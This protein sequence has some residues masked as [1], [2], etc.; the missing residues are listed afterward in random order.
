MKAQ[1]KFEKW[2]S[3]PETFFTEVLG[4]TTLEYYQKDLLYKVAKREYISVRACH[5]VGKT[6]TVARIVLWFLC[7]FRNSIVISTAPTFLQVDTL[8]WGE[9]RDAYKNSKY[10]IGGTLLNTKLKKSDKW[11]AVGFSPQNKAGDSDEQIGST[12]QGFHSDHV[13][14]VFDEATGISA[15]VKKMAEGLM[16]SGIMVRF[17]E[18]GN[19][20]TRACG[21]F[22]T[23]SSPKY[24]KV[25]W[26]C[27]NSPNVRANGFT[28][29]ADIED[30]ID[31]LLLMSEDDRLKAI[32]EYKKPVPHLLSAQWVISYILDWGMDHPL[33]VSKVF[34][35]FPENDDD[36]LMTMKSVEDC[37]ERELPYVDTDLRCIGIDVARYGDD[38]SVLIEMVAK[39]QTSCK[40]AVK[41]NITIVTGLS[42]QMINND[43]KLYRTIVLVD[44][45]GI[46][47]GVFDNL[48]EAQSQGVIHK[49]VE[50]IE[51]H[52]GSG[53][54]LKSEEKNKSQ[55]NIKINA[56][57][58]ARFFNLKSRMFQMLANDVNSGLDLFDD[59]NFLKELPTIKSEPN[60]KG[61][62]AVESKDKYRTRTKQKSPDYADA[63]ALCNFGRYVKIRFGSFK[64]NTSGE[65][66]PLIKRKKDYTRK[67][68]INPTSY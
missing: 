13:L 48:V 45:T 30:E 41:K 5:S 47:S 4:V 53:A 55:E 56:Q 50:L 38:K 52:F 25:H 63:L 46:G 16:T 35:D 66:K 61:Q 58:K 3:K 37:I 59:S 28:C 9:I 31:R 6:W 24:A 8:L 64:N 19:P 21:F 67:T 10:A 54:V 39:T 15:D 14:V 65:N 42:I 17:V 32:E 26:S 60:S 57:T 43:K 62:M 12:F 27:F 1:A 36:V 49:D 40:Q 22:K 20:T 29:K 68:K 44:A 51:V 2:R 11:Y 18:I 23:F 33:V 7:C 34:G